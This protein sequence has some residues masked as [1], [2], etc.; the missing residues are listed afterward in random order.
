MIH[1]DSLWNYST[2]LQIQSR[3]WLVTKYQAYFLARC[4]KDHRWL[5]IKDHDCYYMPIQNWDTSG[6]QRRFW[7]IDLDNKRETWLMMVV[8]KERCDVGLTFTGVQLVFQLVVPFSLGWQ[9]WLGFFV[10][11]TINAAFGLQEGEKDAKSKKN[12][13]GEW[14]I[15]QRRPSVV[16]KDILN[17]LTQWAAKRKS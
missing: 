4:P 11:Q 2:D 5:V 6:L 17:C 13:W 1:N 9:G 14:H 3:S 10:V 16:V 7:Q 15:Y 8:R 12:R